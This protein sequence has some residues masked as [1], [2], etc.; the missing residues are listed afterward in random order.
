MGSSPAFTFLRGLGTSGS[1]GG[2]WEEAL[3]AL[4][5][6]GTGSEC[7]AKQGEM[8]SDST[9]LEMVALFQVGIVFILYS[10]F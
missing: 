4:G 3:G 1:L 2:G 10:A 7:R 8:W 5:E 6:G 9:E